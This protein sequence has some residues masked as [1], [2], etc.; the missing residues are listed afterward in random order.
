MQNSLSFMLFCAV[1]VALSSCSN[2][3]RFYIKNESLQDVRVN[4]NN[5][6]FGIAVGKNSKKYRITRQNAQFSAIISNCNYVYSGID[7]FSGA[8]EEDLVNSDDRNLP[9]LLELSIG[10]DATLKAFVV[11]RSDG[12]RIREIISYG[13]P[14][15]PSKKTCL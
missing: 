15:V 10:N 13:F 5:F 12:V 6:E 9:L 11:N 1:S 2:S 14:L 4:L 8:K 3:G 7:W